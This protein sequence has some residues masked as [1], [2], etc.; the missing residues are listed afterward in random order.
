MSG[1]CRPARKRHR[2]WILP[3]N[4]RCS[5]RPG[6]SGTAATRRWT[7]RLPATCRV[8]R[9]PRTAGA[10]TK[11]PGNYK[12]M[13]PSRWKRRLMARKL[14]SASETSRNRLCETVERRARAHVDPA[15]EN[16]GCGEGVFV[17]IVDGENLPF[18]GRPQHDDFPLFARHKD[19]AVS[20]DGRRPVAAGRASEARLLERR[21]ILRVQAGKDP[22]AD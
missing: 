1:A 3:A 18:R 2:V 11:K 8:T 10:R 22:V 7:I 19:P 6:P 9:L 21:A 20:G 4:G 12:T 14:P 16:R 17:E 5:G 13:E 15:I